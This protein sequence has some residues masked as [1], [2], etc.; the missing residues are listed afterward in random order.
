MRPELLVRRYLPARAQDVL[1]TFAD[2][3]LPVRRRAARAEREGEFGAHSLASRVS[4]QGLVLAG[5]FQGLQLP[6]AGSWG[7]L[8]ARLAGT[9]EKEIASELEGV[10]AARPPLVID[11]GAAEGYYALGLARALPQSVVYAFDID[12]RA[13]RLCAAGAKANSLANVRIRGRVN[14]PVLRH[15]LQPGALVISDCEGYERELLDPNR[16]PGLRE[17]TVLVELHEFVSPGLTSEV[18]ARFRDTH[19][20]MLIDARPRSESDGQHLNHLTLADRR[21]AV[22]EGRPTDPHAM[23]WAVLR[24]FPAAGLC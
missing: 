16:V 11:V 5:I 6:L 2:E 22:D 4:P 12:R 17:A 13:R 14:A 8:S 10:I 24:P 20:C 1:R 3:A 18:L 9:Y 23:Q 21:Q 19:N 15:L 7:G